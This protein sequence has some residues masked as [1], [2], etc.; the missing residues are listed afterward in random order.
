MGNIKYFKY[1]VANKWH[2]P[3]NKNWIDSENPATGDVWAKIPDCEKEDVEKAVSAAKNAFYNG[4]WGKLM[5]AERGRFLRKIG[6]VIS[7]HA[8]RLGKIETQDNGKLPAHITPSLENNAWL[9]DSWNYY[10][11]MCDKFEGK[12][13][14][15]E[16]PNIHN[17]MQWEPFGV[18]AQILPWNSPI[19]TL[20][21]KLAP[22]LAAGNTVVLKPSEQASCS[23]LELMEVLLEADLPPPG[24]INVVTGFGHTSGEPLVDHPDVRMVSFTGGTA[25][26]KSVAKLAAKQIKPVV[27][28]LGGKSPQ[29]VLDDAD[30]EL[31]V[32][33]IASGIF[34]AGGQ[35]CISGSRLLIHKSLIED[36]SEKLVKVAQKAN[37][38]D[39]LNPITQIG[40]IANRKQYESI[41]KDI[42]NA[43]KAG[44]KLLLD[45][46]KSCKDKGYYIGPTIFSNVPNSSELAQNEVFGPVVSTEAWEDED[47]VIK[48]ANDSLYG[49]A[50]GIWSRDTA[51]AMRMANHIEAGTVYINNYFNASAQSPVGGYKQSGYGRE[52]G[53]E[54]MR[55]FMQTKSV[56]L[57][58]KPKQENPFK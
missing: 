20:I 14:P 11:G 18:V 58:T 26:G 39:P 46:R 40:P 51:K 4:P 50:A 42:K 55:C 3:I 28:E 9:V 10:A 52:N 38:G 32:N 56:W 16:L 21:W 53:W 23:T 7:K 57:S 41:L 33:G 45:G 12:L 48:I 5:P 2:D 43:E 6:D 36:F 49:L 35:S 22:C 34:P 29:I 24:V 47:E 44:H 13:I 17:Y 27:M 19:G 15:A 31:A 54:G 8:E 37:V 30:I 1:F 25:G